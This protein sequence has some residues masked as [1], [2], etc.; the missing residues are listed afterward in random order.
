MVMRA[1]MV[2]FRSRNT[3]L[4]LIA[5]LGFAAFCR[6]AGSVQ[7]STTLEARLPTGK[8]ITPTAAPGSHFEMLNPGLKAF[9]DFVAG[10]AISTA[11]SPDQKTLLILTSG[12]N[13]INGADGEPISDASEEYVFVYDI[14]HGEP[15]QIQV[16]KVPDTFAGIAFSPDGRRF[17]VSGGKDDNVHIFSLDSTHHW[18]ENGDPIKLGHSSGLGLQIGKEPL[19][20]GGLAVTQNGEALVITNVYN[21]SVSVVDLARVGYQ[22]N[23]I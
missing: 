13:R 11:V 23:S 6:N 4:C 8:R 22:L 15:K 14:S 16:L 1:L 21:D 7:E 3:C 17:Y 18:S 5:T 12:F 10:Q 9:P 20:A 2:R 19:A